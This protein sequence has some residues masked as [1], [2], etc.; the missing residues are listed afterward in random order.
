M[1][2]SMCFLF[3]LILVLTCSVPAFGAEEQSEGLK[4]AMLAVK[5]VV[6]IPKEYTKVYYSSCDYNVENAEGETVTVWNIEW[7]KPDGSA[8]ISASADERG[9][10]TSMYVYRDDKDENSGG[11]SKITTESAKKAADAF[12]NKCL[13]SDLKGKMKLTDEKRAAFGDTIP[14]T[15]QLEVNGVPAPFVTATVGVNKYTGVVESFDGPHA[16]QLAAFSLADFP[17][18]SP[19]L[20]LEEAQA[21]YLEKL[22]PELKYFTYYNY[23]TEKLKVFAGYQLENGS[24]KAI[25]ADTGEVVDLSYGYIAYDMESAA[26]AGGATKNSFSAVRG[27]E[28]ALSPEEQAAVDKAGNFI[29][30]EEAEKILKKAFS[31]SGEKSVGISLGRDYVEKE[32]YYWRVTFENGNGSVDAKTGEILSYYNWEDTPKSRAKLSAADAIRRA[33]ALVSELA[34]KK[35]QASVLSN[36]EEL[37]A[38]SQADLRDYRVVFTRQENGIP[39]EGNGL[40]VTLDSQTGRIT[41]YQNRWYDS[42]EFPALTGMMDPAAAL[43]AFDA[44]AGMQLSYVKAKGNK[45]ALVYNF[46]N[47]AENYIIDPV[48][49]TALD[50]TGDPYSTYE[51]PEYSDIKGHWAEQT[52]RKL[53]E[54]GYY[55]E[56]ERF[57]PDKNITQE[58]FLRYLYQNNGQ[59]QEEFYDD[60]IRSGI[61]TKAEKAP[62]AAVTRQNAAR[63]ITRY[64]GFDKL[65]TKSNI[66]KDVFTDKV[67]DGYKGYAAICSGMGIM[68]G[69]AK[70]RF[71]GSALM[72]RAEAACALYQLAEQK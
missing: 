45:I 56:G 64:L 67:A 36:E 2:K 69:D 51:L 10:L 50:Y 33:E 38:Q 21:A 23:R 14:F 47:S 68:K 60:L 28:V 35:H 30:K 16:G 32:K 29:S 13:M 41:Y 44:E 26:D 37:Q 55:L 63:F 58:E 19:K 8:A 25:D 24:Q 39:V 12:L 43:Q 6:E 11:L 57:Q 31:L 34:P 71:N 42:A 61:V 70:G 9:N 59:S 4:T 65:A 72:T 7:G 52:I 46:K 49:G 53:L 40:T 1:K 54:N 27:G 3:A 66:F 17:D 5:A 48:K 15:Y 22:A 62:A 20:S 18:G